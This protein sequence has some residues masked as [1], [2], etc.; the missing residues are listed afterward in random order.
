MRLTLRIILSLSFILFNAK[1]WTH[2][3][4][5]ADMKSKPLDRDVFTEPSRET[6]LLFEIVLNIIW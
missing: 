2:H 4:E 6:K 5:Q 1:I 3:A